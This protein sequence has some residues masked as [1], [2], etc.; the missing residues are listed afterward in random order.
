MGQA[1]NNLRIWLAS[2]GRYFSKAMNR[3][4]NSSFGSGPYASA[5]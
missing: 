5:Y 3:N 2:F 1:G 4:P